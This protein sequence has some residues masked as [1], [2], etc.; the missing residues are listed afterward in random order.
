VGLFESWFATTIIACHAVT[1][2]SAQPQITTL[3]M[4]AALRHSVE[5]IRIVSKDFGGSFGVKIGMYVA[6]T[7]VALLARKLDRPMRWTETR[8]EHHLAGGHGNERWFRNVKMTV[9]DD[10]V[11]NS[12]IS[13]C[14][15][16]RC[17]RTRGRCSRCAGTRA[18]STRGSWN[19]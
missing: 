19:A 1:G 13:G 9:Q 5:K 14:G 12:S 4:A 3:M 18:S 6:T 2:G 17:T 15:S 7:A 8:T 10:A 11:T 16:G